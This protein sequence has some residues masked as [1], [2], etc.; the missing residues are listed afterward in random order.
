MD[1]LTQDEIDGL[2][3]AGIAV[4]IAGKI[5]ASRIRLLARAIQLLIACKKGT[6]VE[7]PSSR[8]RSLRRF[9]IM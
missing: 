6:S 5:S 4:G 3:A 8:R 7:P 1:L 9:M 2:S